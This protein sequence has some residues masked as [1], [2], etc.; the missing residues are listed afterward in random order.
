MPEDAP[1]RAAAG[2]RRPLV[3]TLHSAR[4]SR[5]DPSSSRLAG[6]L[7]LALVLAAELVVYA[8]L[9]DAQFVQ[10]D[11]R[12]DDRR[13]PPASTRPPSR[14]SCATGIPAAVHGSLCAG[15]VHGLGLASPRSPPRRRAR[16]ASP[17]LAHARLD[18][19]AFHAAS[20]VTHAIAT[21]FRVPDSAVPAGVASRARDP[22]GVGGGDRCGPLR[23]PSVAG[24]ERR[25]GPRGS[26]TCWP[27]PSRSR[28]CG[29]TS[30]SP[31]APD[32]H[33]GGR[34]WRGTCSRLGRS[35]PVH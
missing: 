11:R 2:I 19:T 26:R 32:G 35:F 33:Y 12:Q 13:E 21:L 20:L 23:A 4:Q 28:R 9:R 34:G 27:A 14:A 31:R 10:W 5:S 3:A 22:R 25:G 1:W 17:R 16:R 18:P 15:D 6:L 24:R 8:P 29:S 7:P 30:A